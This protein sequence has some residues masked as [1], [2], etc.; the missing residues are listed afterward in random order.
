MS[1]WDFTA[2]RED[3]MDLCICTE[4]VSMLHHIV[5]KRHN[6]L[7]S[8]NEI[9]VLT[10]C[11]QFHILPQTVQVLGFTQ[12]TQ[13]TDHFT[14]FFHINNQDNKNPASDG[15]RQGVWQRPLKA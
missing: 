13:H 10:K 14:K 5:R 12:L 15:G 1:D 8:S 2:D 11:D 9:N 6:K 4:L 7:L 3:Q